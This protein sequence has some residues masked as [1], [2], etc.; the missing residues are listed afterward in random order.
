MEKSATTRHVTGLVAGTRPRPDLSHAQAD[1]WDGK[2]F[3]MRV[4]LSRASEA[5]RGEIVV[6]VS[7][8]DRMRVDGENFSPR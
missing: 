3:K 4:S 1:E 5:T 2:R 6:L 8:G 7:R